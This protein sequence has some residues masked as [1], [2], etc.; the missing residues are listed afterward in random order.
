[1][2]ILPVES[3]CSTVSPLFVRISF[4]PF[5]SVQQ[6]LFIPYG[7]FGG[8]R[9]YLHVSRWQNL[10][11]SAWP[12]SR[13]GIHSALYF[14]VRNKFHSFFADFA[15]FSCSQTPAPLPIMLEVFVVLVVSRISDPIQCFSRQNI[16]FSPQKHNFSQMTQFGDCRNLRALN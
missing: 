6:T 9:T 5:S 13:F 14:A 2:L 15:V 3:V 4:R 8:L 1:M 7:Q 12:H 16:P 11:C 10:Q